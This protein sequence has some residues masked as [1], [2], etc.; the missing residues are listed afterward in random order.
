LIATVG[1]VFL[2][3]YATDY[4][5]SRKQKRQQK[6]QSNSHR[7]IN[8]NVPQS[9]M[10]KII[11]TSFGGSTESNMVSLDRPLGVSPEP[12]SQKQLEAS[13]GV[14]KRQSLDE[15]QPKASIGVLKR[16]SLDDQQTK[17]PTGTRNILSSR[18]QQEIPYLRFKIKKPYKNED[19]FGSIHNEH[20]SD[21]RQSS[22]SVPDKHSQK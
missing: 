9:W 4:L 14:L 3:N 11:N 22:T 8:R 20:S 7:E 13:T 12:P 16:Q 1:A 19:S 15:Q 2:L 18:G 17:A 6:D 21:E 5:Q 10:A